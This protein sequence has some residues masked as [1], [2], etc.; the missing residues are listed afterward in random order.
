MARV[1][2]SII[3]KVGRLF[4]RRKPQPPR[5]GRI[6]GHRGIAAGSLRER[7]EAAEAFY[8]GTS[9]EE[10][11]TAEEIEKWEQLSPESV[12]G[13]VH[14]QQPL[15]VH[16]SNVSMAQYFPETNQMMVEFLNGSSYLYDNVSQ[17]EAV[18][19]A[20]EQSKGGWVWT[21]L[22]IRGTKNGHRKPFRKIK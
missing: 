8:A 13:F 16:S 14:D 6:A 21:R 12:E 2:R 1:L 10:P 4:R 9:T 22:R 7:R 20:Q 11:Y 18:E 15:F 5:I 17:Q 3:S 19:F